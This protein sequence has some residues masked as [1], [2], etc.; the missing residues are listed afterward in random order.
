MIK[1]AQCGRRHRDAVK[2]ELIKYADKPGT[3]EGQ[4]NP[5]VA[6]PKHF[7]GVANPFWRAKPGKNMWIPELKKYVNLTR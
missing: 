5:M 7:H 2:H 1:C 6:E 4:S 3:P